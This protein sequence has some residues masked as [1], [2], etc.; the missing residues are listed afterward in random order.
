[1]WFIGRNSKVE[2]RL[3]SD[4]NQSSEQLTSGQN[5][6]TKWEDNGA[7][8]E[9]SSELL[10]KYNSVSVKWYLVAFKMFSLLDQ[11]S[12]DYGSENSARIMIVSVAHRTARAPPKTS[13]SHPLSAHDIEHN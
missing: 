6:P 3:S 2:H 1:M 7:D 13:A 10:R 9:H 5:D 12:R 4:P 8:S 11:S